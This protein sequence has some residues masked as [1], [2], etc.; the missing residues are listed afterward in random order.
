[1]QKFIGII[2]A[3]LAMAM[4][5]NAQ[6]QFFEQMFQ[7]QQQQHQQPQNGPSDSNWYRQQYENGLT[8]LYSRL[9]N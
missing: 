9:N 2:V 8:L 7:G 1:M 5:S 3:M 6:F 4:G